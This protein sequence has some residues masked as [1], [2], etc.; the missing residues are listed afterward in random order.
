MAENDPRSHFLPSRNRSKTSVK[1]CWHQVITHA[2]E[3]PEAHLRRPFGESLEI[4]GRTVYWVN[5][6]IL[7]RKFTFPR[8]TQITSA[9]FT[10]FQSSSPSMPKNGSS[11]L[12]ED[13]VVIVTLQFCHIYYMSGPTF[14]VNI[15]RSISKVIRCDRGLIL[16]RDVSNDDLTTDNFTLPKFFLMNDPLL[17]LGAIVSSSIASISQFEEMLY[18]GDSNPVDALCVTFDVRKFSLNIYSVRHI[19]S[20]VSS[21]SNQAFPKSKDY[22][23]RRSNRVSSA[24]LDSIDTESLESSLFHSRMDQPIINSRDMTNANPSESAS[25]TSNIFGSLSFRKEA[26][27]TLI[28]SF[29]FNVDVSDLNI[30]SISYSSNYCVAVTDASRNQTVF[31]VFEYDINSRA[32]K[33]NRSA[34][35]SAR[36][37]SPIALSLH[38]N[39]RDVILILTSDSSAIFFDP[40]LQIKSQTLCFPKDWITTTNLFVHSDNVYAMTNEGYHKT[41]ITLISHSSLVTKCFK[42]LALVLESPD[43]VT[44]TFLWATIRFTNKSYTEWDALVSTIILT[45]IPSDIQ[46][47]ECPPFIFS[48]EEYSFSKQYSSYLSNIRILLATLNDVG[49]IT[50]N[51]RQALIFSLFLIKE[52]SRLD[53]ARIQDAYLLEE[54]LIHLLAWSGT[55]MGWTRSLTIGMNKVVPC[56][57]KKAPT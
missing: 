5:N 16:S 34:K 17:D 54:L 57:E 52:D 39:T 30:H 9:V 22:S 32:L 21:L 41:D 19:S 50:S 29:H 23:R 47:A 11:K 53:I 18:F 14:L 33:F 31:L 36:S 26:L 4:K 49:R 45:F 38:T 13:A 40:F 25:M 7:V 24:I 8:G 27:L 6:G 3:P 1:C 56:K 46:K 35:M 44:F 55:S 2:M 48:P 12:K 28:D 15:P 42:T 37:V 20:Q 10:S 51:F 43:Y